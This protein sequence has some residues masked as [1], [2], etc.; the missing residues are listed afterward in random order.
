[1][2]IH[3]GNSETKTILGS[4]NADS[5]SSPDIVDSFLDL[6]RNMVP[7]N[8]FRAALETAITRVVN[9]TGE[10]DRVVSYREGTNTLGIIGFCLA[11]GTV[12][13]SLGEAGRLLVELFRIVD[14]VIMRLVM[15]IM[16]ISPIGIA[17]IIAAKILGRSDVC[18]LNLTLY[19]LFT[20]VADIALVMSQL[21]MFILTAVSGV[22]L[23]QFVILQLIYLLIVRA[24]PLR[25]WFGLAQAWV[26][27]WA[28]AS[29]AAA[30]PVTFRCMRENNK[31][32]PSIII[33]LINLHRSIKG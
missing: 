20:A 15:V 23:Y 11:F 9:T 12:L 25:F 30:L 32:R 19:L 33:L 31:V 21:G 22:F 13:G 18:M 5:G 17:S 29:T 1:M 16:Y 8:I 7:G 4:G 6:G 2:I 14:E 24:N 3:P 26:T 10:A 27:A 28:T